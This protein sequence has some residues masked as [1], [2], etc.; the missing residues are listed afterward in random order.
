MVRG[1]L[2][3][4]TILHN[5]V[6]VFMDKCQISIAGL[7]FLL[8]FRKSHTK[9]YFRPFNNKKSS[10]IC[11]EGILVPILD[12]S[13]IHEEATRLG[14]DSALAEFSLL[15]EPVANLL[16]FHDRFL[17]HSAA[18]LWHGKAFLLTGKSGAGK[19]TQLRNWLS[20][21]PEETEVINGDKPVIE[22]RGTGFTVHPSPWPGKERL[23]GTKSAPLGGIIYLE[24]GT[25]DSI[26]RMTPSEAVFPLFLQFLYKP[27]NVEAADKVCSYEQALLKHV[28]VWKLTNTGTADS[29]ILTRRELL[30]EGY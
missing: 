13:A 21:F 5:C 30:K 6:T 9:A 18:F 26:V 10:I 29:A 4:R 11:S 14:G 23:N 20:R 17:F 8:T 2:L 28:P 25:A 3:S 22:Q 7:S 27:E 12:E 19:S 15:V 1:V 24:H 16:L